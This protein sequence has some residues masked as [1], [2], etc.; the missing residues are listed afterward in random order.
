MAET[1]YPYGY[2]RGTMTMSQLRARYEP[3]MHPEFAR[4]LFPWIESMGGLIGIGGGWRDTQPDKPGFAPDGKS[5]H[6]T[7]TFASGIKGYAAVD[8]VAVNGSGVHRAPT[9]AESAT[10]PAYGLHTFIKTPPE[11]WHMQPIEI[12]GWGTW[13]RSG[14]PDPDPTFVLPGGTTPPKEDNDM[15]VLTGPIRSYD[16]RADGGKFAAEERRDV[17]VPGT[18]AAFVNLTVVGA[19]G[20]GYIVAYGGLSK[21]VPATSNVNFDGP[22]AVSNSAWVPLHGDHIHVY[23]STGCHVIVDVQATSP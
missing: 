21:D 18:T 22:D 3:K 5:F 23:A 12:R 19:D 17:K 7:Q 14:R 15:K 1:R 13:D 10:A 16:S 2:G 20:P 11:P 4:R 9:W 6:Q 8:L